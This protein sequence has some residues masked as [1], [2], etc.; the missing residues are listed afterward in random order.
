M[1]S[2]SEN[3]DTIFLFVFPFP[4]KKQNKTKYNKQNEEE[5]VQEQITYNITVF[6]I[7]YK[8][9]KHRIYLFLKYMGYLHVFFKFTHRV[10]HCDRH[11]NTYRV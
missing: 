11:A 10:F 8:K 5:D 9:N 3:K 2:F 1:L 7:L 4:K 6:R